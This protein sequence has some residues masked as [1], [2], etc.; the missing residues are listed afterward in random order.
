MKVSEMTLK[1]IKKLSYTKIEK[2]PK[3]ISFNRKIKEVYMS[4]SCPE[5]NNYY[6]VV[7]QYSIIYRLS[8]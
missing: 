2:L 3:G 5:L 6:L 7:D 4:P 8:Y 1:E